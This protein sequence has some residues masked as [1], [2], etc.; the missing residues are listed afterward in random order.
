MRVTV[1]DID[2]PF[3]S[4]VIFLLKWAGA[5]LVVLLIAGAVMGVVWAILAALVA[6]ILR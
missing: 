1:S 2:I 4:M 5:L 6:M 3:G